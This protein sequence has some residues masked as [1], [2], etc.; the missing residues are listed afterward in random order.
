MQEVAK[1]V[2]L[3]SPSEQDE[4]EVVGLGENVPAVQVMQEVALLLL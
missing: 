1:E 4:Q 2:L 3:N